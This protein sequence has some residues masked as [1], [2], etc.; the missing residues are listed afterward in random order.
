MKSVI[1]MEKVSKIYHLD[2]VELQ[3]L[4]E[5]NLEIKHG[6]FVSIMGA[7]GSG[8]STLLH[9]IGALDIPTKGNVYVN[10][11]NI[12]SISDDKL[13][14]LRGKTIGFIFQFFN[15]YPSLTIRENVELPMMIIEDDKKNMKKKSMEL[16]KKVGLED[17][18]DNYPSQLSGG[19]RQRVAIARALANNPDMI[20]A[21]EPTGNLDSKSGIE[22]MKIFTKLNREGKTIVMVTHEK[23]L[24]KYSK[25]L[26]RVKDGQIVGDD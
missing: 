22:I 2:T 4:H 16:L 7:S 23:S 21:D 5:V 14:R 18:T 11:I 26:I 6:E 15:L 1:K 25:R 13:A 12:A 24:S 3:A 20:L 19:Q 17:R 9:L 8:K 10:G